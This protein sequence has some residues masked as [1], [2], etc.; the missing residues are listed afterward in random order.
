MSNA[1]TEAGRKMIQALA[2]AAR[3]CPELAAEAAK[4][5]AQ[6]ASSKQRGSN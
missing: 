2:D 4:K 6:A 3:A 5:I 1:T